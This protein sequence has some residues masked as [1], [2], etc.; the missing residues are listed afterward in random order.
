MKVAKDVKHGGPLSTPSE[1]VEYFFR[2]ERSPSCLIDQA[3][4][5]NYENVLATFEHAS[6][7]ATLAAYDKLEELKRR[8]LS[9]EHARNE[10][11]V[12]LCKVEGF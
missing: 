4:D 12:E 2:P 9:N 3:I 6:K 1:I 8:G 10:A 5:H 7:R 11:A